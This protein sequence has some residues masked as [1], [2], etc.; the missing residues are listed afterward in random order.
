MWRRFN[1]KHPLVIDFKRDLFDM[2]K[3]R[4]YYPSA[5][6]VI[7][8]YGKGYEPHR[9]QALYKMMVAPNLITR[10]DVSGVFKAP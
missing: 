6:W 5:S 2:L 3:T 10:Q 7:G 8:G 4:K 9:I 1:C